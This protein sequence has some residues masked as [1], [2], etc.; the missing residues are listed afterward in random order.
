MAKLPR[1]KST[2]FLMQLFPG[3]FLTDEPERGVLGQFP[4]N[5]LFEDVLKNVA[6]PRMFN[7]NGKRKKKLP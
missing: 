4:K 1:K 3:Q 2:M 7:E 5:T 6:M